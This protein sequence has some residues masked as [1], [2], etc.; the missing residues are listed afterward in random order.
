ML[1]AGDYI[2]FFRPVGE[3]DRLWVRRFQVGIKEKASRFGGH[4][5]LSVR[6]RAY[7]ND[8]GEL[9]AI[10]HADFVHTERDTAATRDT[11]REARTE[12]IYSERGS[13]H[14]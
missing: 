4:S 12:H 7:R 11:L 14:D 1:W 6:R 5:E 8:A 13:R 10:S 9:I 2:R 3:A